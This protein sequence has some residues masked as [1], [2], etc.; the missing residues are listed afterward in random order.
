MALLLSHRRG[1][2]PL[3][4][5][6][7]ARPASAGGARGHPQAGAGGPSLSSRLRHLADRR[8]PRLHHDAR[9][10]PPRTLRNPACLQGQNDRHP[11]RNP[12]RSACRLPGSARTHLTPRLIQ[13]AGPR[14]RS[15]SGSSTSPASDATSRSRTGSGLTRGCWDEL[16]GVEPN[17][18]RPS[19]APP[20]PLRPP[21]CRRCQ[22]ESP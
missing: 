13:L 11:H 16:R 21:S 4:E 18:I 9:P 12:A 14:W 6:G 5:L 3:L 2:S 1:Q 15:R 10:A 22:P 19:R 17:S 7:P 20:L 8:Y